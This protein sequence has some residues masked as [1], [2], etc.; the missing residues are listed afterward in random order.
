ME[1]ALFGVRVA[2]CNVC[3]PPTLGSSLGSAL[4][5]FVQTRKD[6]RAGK[7]LETE[8]ALEESHKL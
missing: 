4:G 1:G 8:F 6:S 7:D 3:N 5:S 2:L